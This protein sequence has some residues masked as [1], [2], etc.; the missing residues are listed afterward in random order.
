MHVIEIIPT[1]LQLDNAQVHRGNVTLKAGEMESNRVQETREKTENH[2]VMEKR[3]EMES[4][5]AE[6]SLHPPQGTNMQ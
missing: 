3:H 1:T 2:M 6:E 5:Q 4:I